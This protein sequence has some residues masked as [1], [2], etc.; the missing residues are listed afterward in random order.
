[1]AQKIQLRRDTAANWTA[2]NPML[3]QGEM[4]IE[5]VTG[6]TKIGDGVTTWNA[7]PYAPSAASTFIG[8]TAHVLNRASAGETLAG[9][10]LTTPD[11]GVAIGTSL[12]LG[13][14][15]L[16]GSRAITVDTGGVLNIALGSAAGD[17]FTVD[18]DKLVV[19]GDTGRVGIGTTVPVAAL[20]IR[21]IAGAASVALRVVS[22]VNSDDFVFKF[23]GAI[24][25]ATNIMAM[26]QSGRVGIGTAT[27]VGTLNV[28]GQ[29]IYNSDTVVA[30]SVAD[31]T[32]QTKAVH[33]GFDASLIKG[34]IQSGD[35][36][37]QYLGLLLNPLGGNVGIGTTA[38]GTLLHLSGSAAY[39]PFLTIENTN[40][41]ESAGG[42]AFLKT[43]ASPAVNDLLGIITFDGF[44]NAAEQ[45]RF[46]DVWA[47]ATNVTDGAEAGDFYIRT[48]GAGVL[49][50]KF[51]ITGAGNVGIGATNPSSKLFVKKGTLGGDSVFSGEQSL[52][53][54]GGH[55][56]SRSDATVQQIFYLHQ[57]CTYST[58]SKG[59]AFG[60]AL[61]QWEDATNNYPRTRVDFQTTGRS[62]DSIQA[63]NTVL[64]LRDDGNVGIGTTTP[65][66]ALAINGGLHVG[67]DTDPGD[68]NLLADGTIVATGA[69]G[70]NTK[71]A[72]TAY[73]SGGALAAYTTGAF[74]LDSDANMTAM[75][76]LVVAMRAA[77]VANGIMS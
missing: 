12:D 46:V 62:T 54:I 47:A 60:I 31:N 70:C 20:D 25:S 27:P 26:I 23:E 17:D 45:T 41:D 32:T 1:M 40:A 65:A 77:L 38:P 58:A 74:G 59:S 42:L 76:N 29:S 11:I 15:T 14:T 51:R 52:V 48:I 28:V 34:F 66:A 61:S 72:Q 71:T 19:E 7:L 43:S 16:L 33:I 18:T 56:T 75:Y 69:F 37:T 4:G 49:E 44:N 50:E 73:A 64:S 6:L 53:V 21:G 39:T 8:T 13:G 9:L 68:N 22:D 63:G 30:L 36:G 5:L 55:V 24:D 57:P 2:T 3:S 67:G 35:F 10:T